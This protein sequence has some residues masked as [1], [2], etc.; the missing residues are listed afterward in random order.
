MTKLTIET[1]TP[2]TATILI[3]IMCEVERAE[4]KYPDW[5][6]CNVKRAAIILE[7]A[8]ELI[9]EANQLDEGKGSITNLRTETI[10]TAATCIRMLKSLKADQS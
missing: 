6:S 3:E 9:R 1:D 8:G 2:E 4:R 10:Q 7:E 5:P